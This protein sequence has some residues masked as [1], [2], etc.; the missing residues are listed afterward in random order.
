MFIYLLTFILGTI[1][2]SFLNVVIF[3]LPNNLS[4]IKPRSFCPK[5]NITIPFYKNIPI[6]S[7][8]LQ[9]G[10]CHN[11]KKNISVQYP[12]IEFLIGALS[13]ASVYSLSFPELLYFI[14]ISG[15]LICISIIDYKYFIIPFSLLFSS[16]L[17]TIPY[18]IYFSNPLYHIYG[19][20]IGIG[21]LSLI[22]IIDVFV[23][24]ASKKLSPFFVIAIK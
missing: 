9:K 13:I 6:L 22:F 19:M 3:R 10:K 2:G 11:C 5:C 20:V 23:R 4:I 12:I 16:I 1:Y 8:L 24:F 14:I 17:I 15:L 21:Y 18:I 7:F